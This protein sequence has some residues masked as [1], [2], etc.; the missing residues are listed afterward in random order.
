MHGG[1]HPAGRDNRPT[2]TTPGNTDST[3]VTHASLATLF[4]LMLITLAEKAIESHPIHDI[5]AD[6]LADFD[7]GGP[8]TSANWSAPAATGK[9]DQ[10]LLDHLHGL[11]NAIPPHLME[12]LTSVLADRGGRSARP[13]GGAAH[14]WP[15]V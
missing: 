1:E 5:H 8:G 2:M 14:A 11:G 7:D 9:K 12:H 10:D 13:S 15:C 4:E 3:R 6:P